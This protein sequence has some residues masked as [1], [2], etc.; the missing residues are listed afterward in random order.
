MRALVR[1]APAVA[2]LALLLAVPATGQSV[3]DVVDEMYDVFTSSA[4][5]VD[6]YT[7]V[8]NSMGFETLSYFEKEMVDGRPRFRLRQTGAGGGGM[9]FGSDA[10]GSVDIFST[11]QDLVEHGRYAGR[12]DVNG[13]SAHVIVVDDLSQ[14]DFGPPASPDDMDFVPVSGKMFI[15]VS[16]HVPVRMEFDGRATTETGEHDVTMRMN[17]LDYRET[18]GL[19]TPF[20]VVME[21]DG[22]QAMIDPE[23]QEQ[24]EEFERQMES[25]P[26]SQRAMMESMMGD[27]M[28]SIRAMM[29]GGDG[30]MTFEVTVTEVRVN[31]GP[32]GASPE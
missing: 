6:N 20:R 29:A 17:M 30:P 3:Q 32:P 2:T 14:V 21:I 1:S 10:P 16:R 5:G 18:Q 22:F 27:R 28:E 9:N 4:A 15:D 24:L 12:E 26:E 31:A 7:L 13:V 25:M 8:Q 23:M 19:L 11:G